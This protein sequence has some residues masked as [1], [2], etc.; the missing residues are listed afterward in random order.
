MQ[1]N[2]NNSDQA[3][4]LA[5]AWVLAFMEY[6]KN[7]AKSVELDHAQTALKDFLDKIWKS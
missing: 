6:V 1:E 7:P 2:M 5:R 3:I 4:V